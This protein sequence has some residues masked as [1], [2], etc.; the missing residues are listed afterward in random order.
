MLISISPN[1][2]SANEEVNRPVPNCTLSSLDVAEHY[3]LQQFKGKVVYV[4]FWA[5][6]C[7]P[8][9][10]SFPYMNTLD[11]DLKE[12]GLQVLAINLDENPDDAKAF[13]SH[14]PPE[15]LIAADN[16]G[17]CAREFGVKAMPST[18]LVDRKGAI[19]EVHY[20]FRPGE[21]KEFRIKVEK[22]LAEPMN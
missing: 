18:F 6:W 1:C 12:K 17:A 8:C 7:G 22:L 9:L 14:T 15:F 16:N 3:D 20:G 2:T 21:S 13:V 11:R 10:E 5:S 4:D 19:R